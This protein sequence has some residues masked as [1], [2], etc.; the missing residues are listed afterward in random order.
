MPNLTKPFLSLLNA[1][2]LLG[3]LAVLCAEQA[4]AQVEI[5]GM[6]DVA[7]K[8]DVGKENGEADSR[9]NQAFK[10]GGPFSL[11]RTRFF[12]DGAATDDVVVSTTLL[13][14]E[15]V[16]HME[17]EGVYIRFPQVR[18]MDVDL[19]VGKMATVFGSFAP[20]SFG[21]ENA[22]IG[23]PLMYHYFS[24][25]QGNSVPADNAD[26]LGRRDAA[27]NP[28]RGLPIV[29]DACWNTGV[30][31]IGSVREWEYAVAATRGALSNPSA[32]GNDGI[33]L[34]GHLGVRPTMGLGLG[35][36]FAYGPYLSD[37]AEQDGDFPA[38]KTVRDFAQIVYALDMDYSK[39]HL[40]LFAEIARN[41]WQVPNL[42]E[43]GLDN[44]AGYLEGRYALLPGL[45][46]AVRYGQIVYGEIADGAGAKVPWDY[47]VTRLESGLEY[48][49]DRDI[50][51][52]SVIQLNNRDGSAD[53]EDHLVGLQLATFF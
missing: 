9:I 10:G 52:K 23:S 16:G 48:Y 41:T 4:G 15:V 19:Q 2:S 34:V 35:A 47:D 42:E 43:S 22:L 11:V 29:Y 30:E 53:K 12:V 5:S 36:S 39:G 46:L 1:V 18:Q 20:R 49:I 37:G 50:R 24:S 44:V 25:V 32:R 38:D 28:G 45:H 31:M 26:Q 3:T 40:Q 33:Q 13:Y 21:V 8:W 14:D 17:V 27:I 7:T 51:I 6:A